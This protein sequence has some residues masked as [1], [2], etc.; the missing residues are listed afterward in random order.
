MK[1]ARLVRL[2][3]QLLLEWTKDLAA[4]RGKDRCK[5][6]LGGFVLQNGGLRRG[7]FCFPR[8]CIF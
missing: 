2:Y 3:G 5:V 1:V 8:R 4:Q 7:G 6:R